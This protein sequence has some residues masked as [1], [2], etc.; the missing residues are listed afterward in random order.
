[1]LKAESLLQMDLSVQYQNLNTSNQIVRVTVKRVDSGRKRSHMYSNSSLL[2][3]ECLFFASISLMQHVFTLVEEV[4]IQW[5]CFI[6]E[7]HS[8][9]KVWSYNINRIYEQVLLVLGTKSMDVWVESLWRRR[10]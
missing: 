7:A 6:K 9:Q 8:V 1:M 3:F 10:L 4:K 2:H 5:S